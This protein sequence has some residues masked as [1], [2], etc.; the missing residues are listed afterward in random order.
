MMRVARLFAPLVA[1]LLATPSL[2]ES[3]AADRSKGVLPVDGAGRPLNLD[4][5]AGT[6]KDWKA[7]GDAFEGPPIEGDAVRARRGDMASGHAGKFWVGSYEKKGDAARGTL[8]SVPFRVTHPYASFLVGAGSRGTTRAEV[9]R[10]DNSKVIF[11]ASGTDVED[12]HPVAVDLRDHKGAEVFVRLVDDDADGWGHL[13]FDDFRFHDQA[14]KFE[15]A[16]AAD[17]VDHDGL[18][19]EDAATAMTVPAGFK[20]KL[21]AGEPDV[22]QPIAFTIDDRGRLWVAEAYS[23]PLHVPADKARDRI[24]IFE[25]ADGDGHFDTRKV[26]ADKLNLVSGLEVGFGGVYVGAAPNFLFIP[27]QDGDDVPDGPPVILL[28]GWAFQDT[29]ETL[30]SFNWGPDGWLYGC[31]GVFTHSVVGKPGTPEAGRVPI[32]AGIWRYH[33]TRHVFEVFAEGTSNPWGVDFDD[34]GQA[35]ET[36]CVIPH[37]YHMIQGARY[38]RQAGPHINPYTYDDIKTIAD[39]RHYVGGNPHGGNG[40]SDTS[41]GGHAHAGALIYLGGAWPEEYRGSLLMNNIHGARL[42]RDTLEPKGSGFVGRH[43]PDFLMAHDRWS[44]VISLKTGPD[45][46]LYMIDWYDKN[47][48]HHFNIEGHDRTNGRIFKVEYE[49]ASPTPVDLAKLPDDALV[50]LQLDRN[51]WQVRHARRVLQERG[52]KPAVHEALARIAFSHPEESRRLRG[53]WALHATGGLDDAQVARGLDDEGPYVRAWTI[54]L[55]IDREKPP[56]PALLGKLAELAKADPSPVVRLYL[57]SACQRLGLDQRSPILSGL[58]RHGE[59]AKD[60]NLPMMDWY[61]AEPL[62]A[63]DPSSALR[64]A[65]ESEIPIVRAYLARRVA[66]VGT[67]E[68]LAALVE[69]LRLEDRPDALAGMLREANE[70]LKGRTGA[71]MPPAWPDVYK[72]LSPIGAAR[73][74]ATTLGLTFGDPA[75]RDALRTVLD[76]P[77]AGAGPR[78]DALAALLKVR[79]PGLAED[80]QRLA[81]DPDLRGPAIR[82]LASYDDPKTPEVLLSAYEKLPAADRRDA[83][84]TLATRVASA[85]ALLAAVESKRLPHGDLSAD[86][87]RQLH[88]LKDRSVDA[89]LSKVWGSVRETG[90]AR[91]KLIAR[92]KATL[93]SPPKDKDRP[94]V[95][96]GRAVYAKTCAQCHTLFGEGGKV[97]P[98]LTGSN[99]ADLDYVLANVLDPDALI[100]KD[101]L[102]HVVATADGRTLTGII[103]AEDKDAITLVTANETL[104]LPLSTVED[105]KASEKS[106]MPDDLWGPLSE[107]E[108]RSLIAYLA[109]PSQVPLPAADPKE[110]GAR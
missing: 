14:P 87:V 62:A 98:E 66:A 104:V 50:A 105:R 81:A 75:A 4:F 90:E 37:L 22:K 5:E 33:P 21:F 58:V 34:H 51:E 84:N 86:L 40:R 110:A 31:H 45:G 77:K 79:V 61:A 36:A 29:H 72:K 80:M 11:K 93:S 74:G 3:E 48:C 59:D 24:L 43:A 89:Q 82:G 41:G 57:A 44:Q 64:L 8:T 68:A 32:D 2:A 15:T 91:V 46:Q 13:N 101:Y 7:E 100:G 60:H 63:A 69:A 26:F 6:L 18:S 88:N 76:D 53:L 23:Y 108:I 65:R 1:L 99:R 28:D 85:K 109:S 27:D 78:R 30:N 39:H 107:R 103:K 92:T 55:A 12:M 94:D 9:V 73:E 54:Q 71:P 102:A 17:V 83:L 47:Q 10:K 49:G 67:P 106:M 20:V 52:P 19:P 42:N 97:G 56:T 95:S 70:A 25:D 96:L 38:E 35:I 16:V